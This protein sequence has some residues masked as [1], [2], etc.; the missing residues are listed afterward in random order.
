MK[1]RLTSLKSRLLSWLLLATGLVLSI[2]LVVSVSS[3]LHFADTAYDSALFG[4]ARSI[5][6]GLVSRN[7]TLDVVV[8]AVALEMLGSTRGRQIFHRVRSP[9]GRV[10]AGFK[11]APEPPSRVSHR[12]QYFDAVYRGINLRWVATY[13]PVATP[14][15]RGLVL[16]QV[17]EPRSEREILSH[18]I[19]LTTLLQQLPLALLAAGV[20]WWGVHRSLR[21]LVETGRQIKNRSERDRTPISEQ[22]I[23]SE[24]RP[25]IRAINDLLQR[26]ARE[27]EIQEQ[28]IADASHQLKTPLAILRANTDLALRQPTREDTHEILRRIR[29]TI[30]QTSRLTHQ[31][32]ALLSIDARANMP[33]AVIDLSDVVS[34]VTAE[35]VPSAMSR[36][37]DL[38]VEIDEQPV[39]LMADQVLIAELVGNL[40]DNA[41]H[42]GGP[43]GRVT[44]RTSRRE[45]WAVLEVMDNG[46]GIAPE[47]RELVFRRF[48]TIN[49]DGGNSC[50]LG[51][52]VVRQIAEAHGGDVTLSAPDEGTGLTVT[53]RLPNR[54]VP[55]LQHRKSRASSARAQAEHAV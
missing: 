15:E 20:I 51:L 18:R 8:P 36:E 46:P 9:E 55:P 17:G 16:V 26:T 1:R 33:K 12:P 49:N 54:G 7:G 4:S 45:K 34:R 42:Y 5:A 14:E 28:F 25:L 48:A 38:G 35:R 24:V 31:L 19:V 43:G 32:L 29:A 23:P 30:E 13:I 53:V 41:V 37:V 50:G 6:N 22:D 52:A 3:A 27:V 21:P 47:H 40:I 10:L 11:D 2:N 44:L 39:R